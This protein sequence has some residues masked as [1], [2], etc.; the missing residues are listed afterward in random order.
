MQG[1]TLLGKNHLS[2]NITNTPR[3][4][5]TLLMD[6]SNQHTT[7]L[8]WFGVFLSQRVVTLESHSPGRSHF[9]KI[10]RYLSFFCSFTSL[11]F[12]SLYIGHVNIGVALLSQVRLRSPLFSPSTYPPIHLSIYLSIYLSICLA[13]CLSNLIY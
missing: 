1:A 4:T 13:P 12:S 8:N 9:R 3:R 5:L 7:R 11:I 2:Q 6:E 10:D